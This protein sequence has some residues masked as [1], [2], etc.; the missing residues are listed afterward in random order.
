M[1]DGIDD[2][3]D[4]ITLEKVEKWFKLLQDMFES[5]S[6]WNIKVI[7]EGEQIPELG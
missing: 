5:A 6:K 1:E 2:G 4:A 7:E 3:H